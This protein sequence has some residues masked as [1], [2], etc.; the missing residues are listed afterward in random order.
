M[1]IK[2]VPTTTSAYYD[3]MQERTMQKR[4]DV[5]GMLNKVKFQLDDV[6][7]TVTKNTKVYEGLGVTLSDYKEYNENKYID[8]EF[9]LMSK[10]L[11]INRK[12]NYTMD[13]I[14]YSLYKLA[15]LQKKVYEFSESLKHCDKLLSLSLKEYTEIL[16]TFYTE[17]HKHMI[18]FGE[19]Y[20]F[21]NGLGWICINR[22]RIEKSKPHLDYAATKKR[23]QEILN[24]GGT[25]YNKEEE[26]WCKENNIKY[27]GVDYRVFKH[28]EYC[29]EIPLLNST[30]KD[31]NKL[32]FTVSD[33]RH[34]SLRGK[35]NEEIIEEYEGNLETICGLKLDLKTKLNL[36]L[37]ADSGIY[38]NFIR[39]ENQKS[40]VFGKV[41]WKDR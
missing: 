28:D 9:L 18:L 14:S 6:Y 4:E 31:G 25:L 11:F 39:N 10:G 13:A 3:K 35:T 12:H 16:R 21:E 36:C 2:E 23:K 30:V 1:K 37:K 5:M 17:V 33:Y 8:G 34:R 22:C 38:L 29:Y 15:R 40:V 7:D 27:N 41:N 32:K 20:A 24:E 26:Q 19:G